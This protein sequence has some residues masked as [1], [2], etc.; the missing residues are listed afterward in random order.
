M[1]WD[2]SKNP[3]SDDPKTELEWLSS[4][5]QNQYL[6]F[7]EGRETTFG[8]FSQS[9]RLS[10]GFIGQESLTYT[11]FQ[12]GLKLT[13]HWTDRLTSKFILNG[14]VTSEREF[15]DVEGGYRLCDVDNDPGSSTFND[16]VATVGIGSLYRY[17]RN[18]LQAQLYHAETRNELVLDK[19]KFE[20]GV[21]Y[22]WQ[23]IDDSLDEYTFADSSDYVIN[24]ESL[25]NEA[26]LNVNRVEGYVQHRWTP[27]AQ[28]LLVYGVR[29]NYFSLNN[30]LLISPRAQYAYRFP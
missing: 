20:A 10:V 4:Y 28:H 8:T 5:A 24:L 16:C 17:G 25:D 21:S 29:L 18:V 19:S 27:N 12:N 7:P 2:L 15:F 6:V 30:Q 1:R 26:S 13:H 11:T 3:G 23:L 22:S 14:V 9:F